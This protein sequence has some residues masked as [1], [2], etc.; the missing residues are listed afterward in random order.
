[1]CIRDRA[2]SGQTVSDTG[3]TTQLSPQALAAIKLQM[4]D[5]QAEEDKIALKTGGITAG[6]QAWATQLQKVQSAGEITFEALDQAMK[7]FEDTT[8]NSCLL[9]TSCSRNGRF[10]RHFRLRE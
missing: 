3:E 5:I 2:K 8:A 1:M 10:P 9:Y 6:F 4:L 7:G